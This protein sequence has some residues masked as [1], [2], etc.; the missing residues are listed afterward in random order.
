M[1]A[2]R[3]LG[4]T[5]GALSRTTQRLSTGLRINN[6]GDDPSGLIMSE[7]L[8]AQVSGAEQAI[9]NNQD[10][11]NYA[12]TA[13]GALDEM[14]RLLRDARSLAVASAN[15]GVLSQ[16]QIQANQ[17]QFGLLFGSMNRVATETAFGQ[18]KLLDGTAGVNAL[19]VNS[20]AVKSVYFAGKIGDQS[21]T[22]DGALDVQVTTAATKASHTG[23][24]TVA[25]ASLAAYQS[26]AVGFA[27]QFSLNGS[28]I[29]VDAN[30]TWS[31]VVQKINAASGSTGVVAEAV[32]AGGNGSIQ[33]RSVEYGSNAKINLV[34]AGGVI[35]SAA[36]TVSQAGT[37]AVATVTLGS[38]DPVTFTAGQ[39]NNDGLTLQDQNG[40][41][42][43][44]TE[45]GN[46]VGTLTGAAQV[47]AGGV[48]FQ[49]GGNAGQVEN[50]SLGAFTTSALNVDNLDVT[51]A[52]GATASIE[53]ID[54]A[55]EELNRRRGEIG[56]FMKN[57]LEVNIRSLGVAKESM[58][59]TESSIRDIDVA[60]E[61]TY[62]TKMQILQQS[63]LAVLAQ[64]NSAPQAVLSLLQG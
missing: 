14:S 45:A 43:V 42:I 30:E 58:A 23:T 2:L 47:I 44:L 21:I 5:N 57:V 19:V 53:A 24:R 41:K 4:L 48:Q 7:S 12:K 56:S 33:L 54:K 29:Q 20:T 10:A 52:N 1:S 36:G 15:T 17:T 62:Y 63:G 25:A 6:A 13:E 61:M 9:R 40:N 32:Y 31:E 37:N 38:L 27:G 16:S 60:E 59:A 35:Q 8:R 26:T 34:D 11:L 51:T 22:E 39:N 50:L 46:A 49:V 64:A 18:K 3:N 55:L 28:T